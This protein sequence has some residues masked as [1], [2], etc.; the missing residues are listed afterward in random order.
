[1]SDYKVIFRSDA[2]KAN[3][4]CPIT[5]EQGCPLLIETIQVSRNTMTGD[6]YLQTKF[7]NLTATI[8]DSFS[9]HFKVHFSN[10]ET[11]IAN[12]HPL[13]TDIAPAGSYEAPPLYLDRGDIYGVE[14]G[15]ESVNRDGIQWNSSAEP[16]ML[17]VQRMLTLSDAARKERVLQ[18]NSRGC[19][20]SERAADHPVEHFGTWTRC[21]CGQLNVDTPS[22]IECGL[23]L[24]DSDAIEDE[25]ELL[26]LAEKRKT[27]ALQEHEEKLAHRAKVKKKAVHAGKYAAIACVAFA[28]CFG[29][30]SLV[31]HPAL[32][33]QEAVDYV[34]S[35]QYS[36]AVEAFSSLGDYRDSRKQLEEARLLE[37]Q[38]QTEESYIQALETYNQGLYN[39][40]LDLLENLPHYKEADYWSGKCLVELEQ[41][42]KAVAYFE[43]VPP[44]SAYFNNSLNLVKGCHYDVAIQML[45]EGRI[46]SAKQELEA[47]GD[48]S[49]TRELLP[50]VSRQIDMQFAGTYQKS[51]EQDHYLLLI[52]MIDPETLEVSYEAYFQDQMTEKSYSNIKLQDDGT[53]L[54]TNTFDGAQ[55]T[56]NRETCFI[57]NAK[58]QFQPDAS[59][60]L[61]SEGIRGHGPSGT[62]R[63]RVSLSISGDTL[64]ESYRYVGTSFLSKE[65]FDN[66][67]ENLYQRISDS[68]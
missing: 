43:S 52:C 22:C 58:K 46:V 11:S 16:I 51:D 36:D 33:Y 25:A 28:V 32:R 2:Q 41:P 10:G 62:S 49:N 30:Y 24:D 61:S 17:P 38:Q 27:R 31:V 12:I 8:I 34:E 3:P 65:P 64:T 47:A 5:W 45:K 14:G 40:A 20:N 56:S 67:G 63:E 53:L 19:R 29:I 35:G 42:D 4:P 26:V 48:Y 13:D 21:A 50:V 66:S 57:E 1:M 18:L 55:I 44:Q 37:T 60:Y 54:V 39:D 6:A 68:E 23:N 15:I 59:V 7:H 9:A